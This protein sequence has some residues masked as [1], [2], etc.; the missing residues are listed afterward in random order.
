[1]L[2]DALWERHRVASAVHAL[3]GGMPMNGGVQA[4][5]EIATRNRKRYLAL[6]LHYLL[7]PLGYV[8]FT[9]LYWIDPGAPLPERELQGYTISQA[10]EADIAYTCDMLVRDHPA[11]VL[12]KRC[13]DGHHCF[14]A[15]Y[16]G[17]VVGYDWIAFSAVQEQEYRIELDRD[18]AFCLDA[19]THAAHRG[20]GV[21]YVLLRRMLE[22]AARSGKTKAFTAV[23]LFN[24]NSWK[25]HIRMG[26][27]RSFT[28]A[29]FRPYF[30]LKRLPWALT[31]MQYPVQLDWS[32]HAWD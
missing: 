32:R 29:Y 14:V 9:D 19:Y 25:S 31:P 6:I 1:M 23:S 5:D 24:V 4:E 15:R 8:E 2:L 21:H 16:G 7:K 13:Q 30:T 28:V 26:W 3:A 17:E 22:H 11:H 12:R 20:K 10:G 18:H 27:R